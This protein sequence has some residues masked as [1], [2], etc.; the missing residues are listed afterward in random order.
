MWQEI[1][2]GIVALLVILYVGYKLYKTIT[3][4]ATHNPCIGCPGC[5]LMNEVKAGEDCILG[6]VNCDEKRKKQT[7]QTH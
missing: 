2:T 5:S 1:A 3:A 7:V 4:P 6:Q